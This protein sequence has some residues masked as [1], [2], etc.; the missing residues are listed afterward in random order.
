M[1]ARGGSPVHIAYTIKLVKDGIAAMGAR[2]TGDLDVAAASR[3]LKES[4][5][6]N[7]ILIAE[8]LALLNDMI[9]RRRSREDE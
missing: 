4:E 9:I 8:K 2:G 1:E 7:K 5:A 6:A 3:W